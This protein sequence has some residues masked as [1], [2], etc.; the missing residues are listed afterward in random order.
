[1][2][3]SRATTSTNQTHTGAG[4]WHS[5]VAH[6]ESQPPHTTASVPCVVT[7]Y[8]VR[9][10]GVLCVCVCAGQAH[11]TAGSLT[12]RA[13]FPTTAPSPTHQCRQMCDMNTT[14]PASSAWSLLAVAGSPVHPVTH[15]MC[16]CATFCAVLVALLAVAAY[17][18]LSTAGAL[19]TLRYHGDDRCTLLTCASTLAPLAI[20]FTPRAMHA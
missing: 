1:M 7:R 9:C 3:A 8:A 2:R 6:S 18:T 12:A 15:T 14:A 11:T 19:R 10:V 4:D 5:S 16:R 20:R 13:V 17:S